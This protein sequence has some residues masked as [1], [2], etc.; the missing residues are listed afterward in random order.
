MKDKN[1]VV[2]W[3]GGIDSTALIAQLL[4]KGWAV[5]A[6]VFD[7]YRALP[8]FAARE[9][10]A[11]TALLNYLMPIETGLLEVHQVKSDWIWAFSPDGIEIPRR[12]RLMIDHM[13]E[14]H[15]RPDEI[16][17]IGLG[18]YIGADTWV[19]QDHVGAAD[20]DA[21]AL[22]AYIYR[23][24]GLRER[25]WTLADF[26]EARYK[27]QRLS[28]GI[29]VLGDEVM[30]LTTNCLKDTEIHCGKCYKCLERNVA[31]CKLTGHDVTKYEVDPTHHPKWST[32]LQQMHGDYASAKSEDFA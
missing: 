16:P 11:R 12:N 18:E 26:G 1:I 24:Y 7:V 6:L 8:L 27:H 2:A 17:N 19:V 5:K 3:S 21:R 20:A 22:C 14:A 4:T 32:Y 10:R 13:I 25:L 29:E 31:F 23:E 30:A 9:E 15:C 28:L